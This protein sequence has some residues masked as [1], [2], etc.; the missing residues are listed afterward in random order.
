MFEAV[1]A[2]RAR[3]HY[4]GLSAD[5]QAQIDEI[6]HLL[7]SDPWADEETKVVGNMGRWAAGVYDDGRWEVVYRVL[8]DRFIEIVGISRI[9]G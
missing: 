4:D 7:E 6:V 2:P 8:D 5:E 3:S 9:S 1:F